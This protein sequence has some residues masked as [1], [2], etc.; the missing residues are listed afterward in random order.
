MRRSILCI[1]DY[2]G[3]PIQAFNARGKNAR[4]IKKENNEYKNRG[5]L[6]MMG[7]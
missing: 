3:T 1:S 5:I 4:K 6:S 2:L 7:M